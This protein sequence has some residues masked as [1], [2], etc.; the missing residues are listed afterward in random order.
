M[1]I[2]QAPCVIQMVSGG[3][4]ELPAQILSQRPPGRGLPRPGRTFSPTPARGHLKEPVLERVI[5]SLLCC[6]GAEKGAGPRIRRGMR[7]GTDE[8]TDRGADRAGHYLA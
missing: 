3:D 2:R 6:R 5:D 4:R 7:L 8:G 1:P